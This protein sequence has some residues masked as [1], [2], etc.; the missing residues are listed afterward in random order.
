L[1]SVTIAASWT[2]ISEVTLVAQSFV[3]ARDIT[4]LVADTDFGTANGTANSNNLSLAVD[5]KAAHSMLVS[6][7]SYFDGS[8]LGYSGTDFLY[9]THAPAEERANHLVAKTT[10]GDLST[11]TNY[12]NVASTKTTDYV[13]AAVELLLAV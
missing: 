12:I 3:N 13:V 6:A 9:N 2:S 8:L 11:G 1:S 4:A 5:C 7:I 10:N